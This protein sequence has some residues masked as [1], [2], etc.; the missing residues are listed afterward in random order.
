MGLKPTPQASSTGCTGCTGYT[1]G[2]MGHPPAAPALRLAAMSAPD[3]CD[4]DLAWDFKRSLAGA[5]MCAPNVVSH[6]FRGTFQFRETALDCSVGRGRADQQLVRPGPPVR[7]CEHLKLIGRLIQRAG[8]RGL[9]QRLHR[10]HDRRRRAAHNFDAVLCRGQ[11]QGRGD[12][13]RVAAVVMPAS[14][15]RCCARLSMC[16]EMSVASTAPFGPMRQAMSIA[17]SPTPAALSST[18]ERA[19]TCAASSIAAVA[20]HSQVR[21]KSA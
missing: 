14:R 15:K 5:K 18:R 1:A 11:N 9:R 21:I 4:D 16:G 12:R 7:R 8:L 20:S 6:S 2:L 19:V 17:W 13:P 3:P 10:P